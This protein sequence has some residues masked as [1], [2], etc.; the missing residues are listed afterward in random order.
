MLEDEYEKAA[1]E[2][3]RFK[4]R[5]AAEEVE[6]DPFTEAR[7]AELKRLCAEVK[8]IWHAP[9]TTDL[10]RKQLIR[11][12]VEKIVID[13]VEPER[14]G[15]S[16]LWADGRPRKQLELLRSPYFHRLIWEW[17]LEDV[18]P[19]VM[20][21]RLEGM[22]A[23]TQQANAWSVD[24]VKRTLAILVKRRASRRSLAGRKHPRR[25]CSPGK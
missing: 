13:T 8:K 6:V 2:I 19:Q 23:R 25:A 9:T 21:E 16:I 24:T 15:L 5:L 18:C 17:H 3:E 14:I 7:W 11:M 22:G 20:V 1:A 12:L 4:Q 10:D